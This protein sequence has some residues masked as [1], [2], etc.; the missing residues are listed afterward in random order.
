MN[1]N[2]AVHHGRISG[3]TI[4]LLLGLA[5]ALGAC[6]RGPEYG[7]SSPDEVVSSAFAM[8]RDG[9]TDR[10]TDLIHA[11]SDDMR[12]VLDRFGVLLGNMQRLAE[13]VAERMPREVER[14][15]EDAIARAQENP[16][17]P[18]VSAFRG[19]QASGTSADRSDASRDALGTV[20][21]APY[22]WLAGMEG[23]LTT[24][25]LADDQA[26]VIHE[27]APAW[28]LPMIEEG[29]KWYISLPT[30]LPPFARFMPQTREEWA[31]IGSVV[32]VL[33]NTIVDLERDVRAGRIGS[34]GTLGDT[35]IEK[36]FFPGAIA[37]TAYNR[38]LQVRTRAERAQRAFSSRRRDWAASRD[39]AGRPVPRELLGAIDAIA[40]EQIRAAIRERQT[41]RFDQ[42][43]DGEFE[44]TIEDWLERVG[45]R[46]E[47]VGRIDDEAV[48]AAVDSWR[49]SRSPE[50]S[51]GG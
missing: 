40:P 47:V 10:L 6:D 8:V 42:M 15:R 3:P 16:T 12:A 46:V 1:R 5:A 49:K 32:D 27:D 7:Q 36:L 24:L 34:L 43:S 30:R 13:R 50:R 22:E 29:G 28:G 19:A 17:N 18:I 26:M 44:R 21:A 37:F 25:R 48:A 11:D 33:N 45:L 9:N 41:A 23:K 14:A 39:A 20:L 2:D 4:A 35:A 51:R 38:E 31:I